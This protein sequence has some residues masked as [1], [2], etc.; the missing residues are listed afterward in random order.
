M[1]MIVMGLV[2]CCAAGL[3]ISAEVGAE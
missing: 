2:V 3:I 1:F